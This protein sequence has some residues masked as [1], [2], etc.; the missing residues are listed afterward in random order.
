DAMQ[1]K[2]SVSELDI[3]DI[4]PDLKVIVTGD[5]LG[6]KSIAGKVT[7]VGSQ[8]ETSNNTNMA[9]YPVTI[10]LQA[11]SDDV[12]QYIRLGMHVRLQ[13]VI[14][15][16]PKAVVIPKSAVRGDTGNYFVKRLDE[17]KKQLVSTPV[18]IGHSL[19]N[20]IEIIHGLSPGDR[21]QR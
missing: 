15:H 16:N 12:K 8:E 17:Q 6:D 14:Y 11:P 9:S 1:I 7:T 13:I 2:V 5:S 19:A 18:K 3:N 20:G 21:I 10:A 4:K